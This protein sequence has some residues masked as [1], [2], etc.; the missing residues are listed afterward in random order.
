[1]N[2][3]LTKMTFRKQKSI[4]ENLIKMNHNVTKDIVQKKMMPVDSV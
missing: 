4:K 2:A 3:Y 1:M